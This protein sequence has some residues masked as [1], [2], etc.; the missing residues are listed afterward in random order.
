MIKVIDKNPRRRHLHRRFATSASDAA[1]CR[2]PFSRAVARANKRL[3]ELGWGKLVEGVRVKLAEVGKGS[4]YY[5][6]QDI[7]KL[8]T[9]V[10]Y[11]A[12]IAVRSREY[13]YLHEL[14]HRFNERFLKRK[15]RKELQA[16][17]GDYDAPYKQVFT[18]ADTFVSR[19]ATT[20][21]A[22]DFAETFAV[23]VYSAVNRLP[24]SK[25][26]GKNRVCQRK[27][28][29]VAALLSCRLGSR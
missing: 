26:A 7:I 3:Y 20:H 14:G 15:D 23:I 17:F 10:A 8:D 21:P 28:R 4:F 11:W 2:R 5:F 22:E 6:K 19:Y 29:K 12:A 24:L 27:V 1:S 18:E 25:L 9:D 16:L 13:L